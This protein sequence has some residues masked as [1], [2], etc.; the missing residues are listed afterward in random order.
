MSR[1]YKF[2]NQDRI[3][4]VSYAVVNW[5]DIFTRSIYKDIVVK[6]LE[7]CC[8]TK[9]LEVYGWVIMTNHVHL[10]IGS[11]EKK[12]ED[13]MRDHK[14]HTSEQ[15][16]NTIKDHPQESR[17]DWV[18]RQFSEA[19]KANTNNTNYQLWQQ[20]NK[21]IELYTR[22]VIFKYLNYLHNNPVTAGFVEKPEDWLYSSARDYEGKT[23]LL[24]CLIPIDIAIW[25]GE[26]QAPATKQ[27]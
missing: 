16:L 22:E 26:A 2:C 4:F 20:S 18:L 3:Y 11:H 27:E 24:K 1:R 6:S 17:K 23:G 9:G 25:G 14:R 10:I 15:L 7:H 8:R 21:P 12:L 13:I 19:G 5:V